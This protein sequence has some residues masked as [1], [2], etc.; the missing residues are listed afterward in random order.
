MMSKYL[1]SPLNYTGGKHKLLPQILP[2]FPK[3]IESFVDLFAGGCNVAINVDANKIIANDIDKNIIELYKYFQQNNS[4]DILQDIE[5]LIEQYK[6][7]NTSKYGYE[8]YKTNSSIGVGRYNKKPY[9]R[10]RAAYNKNKSPLLFY[11][12]LIFAFNNQVRFNSKGEFNTPV[13]KRDFNKNMQKNFKLF[14]DKLDALDITFTSLDFKEIEV[15]QNA[16]VY[17]DPPYLATLAA[18]NENGGWNEHKEQELLDYMDQLNA[19][20]VKF[21][22]SN[23]FQNK[24]KKNELLIA[25]SA[26]YTVHHLQHTYHNCNYQAKNKTNDSTTEVLVTNY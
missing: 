6:L 9:E 2:L 1:K 8:K 7:S 14:V 18:Y 22:L 4:E 13:N 25:W 19:Q 3:R 20:G 26:K 12:T 10:L 17:I 21:A 5:H 15:P 16:F 24:G 23:V 11:T